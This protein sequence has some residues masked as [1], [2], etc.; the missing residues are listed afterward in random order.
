M[1][2][3]RVLTV[4][5]L[6]ALGSLLFATPA[7]AAAPLELTVSV[8]R[9]TFSTDEAVPLTFTVTN[10][11]AGACGLVG[12]AEGT[13]QVTAVT[14][15]GVALAPDY[16]EADYY[17]G[18]EDALRAG[19]T[20]AQPGGQVTFASDGVVAVA[21]L[22]AGDGLVSRWD[23]SRPGRYQV[24][25]V[26]QVPAL[27]GAQTC[28]GTTAP[29]T[30]AFTV[31]G[32]GDPAR[33]GLLVALVVILALL[34]VAGVLVLLIRRR[35]GAAAAL[36]LLLVLPA[37]VLA[38]QRADARILSELDVHD[39]VDACIG[40]FQAAGDP[41]GLLPYLQDIHTPPVRVH[42]IHDGRDSQP[43]PGKPGSVE[44]DGNSKKPAEGSDI[45]WDPQPSFELDNVPV[46]ACSAL[47]HELAHAVDINK[48]ALGEALCGDSGVKSKEV[49]ATTAENAYRATQ[50]LDQR[51]SYHGT[52][53]PADPNSCE[54]PLQQDLRKQG[55][56]AQAAPGT[57]SRTDGDPHLGTY[58]QF[59]YD[60]QLVGEFV[61][62]RST[63]GQPLEIQ[64]R[65]SPAGQ[66][67]NQSLNTAVA[68]RVG[69][70]KVGFYLVDGDIVVHRDGTAVTLPQGR[71]AL[72]DGASITRREGAVA[73]SG[74]GYTVEWP[75]GST[76]WL[77]RISGWGLR[78]LTALAPARKGTV[79]G[80]FGDFDGNPDNDLVDRSGT[81]VPPEQVAKF[82]DA[83]RVTDAESLFDYAAGQS[84]ATFTDR[85]FP[86]KPVTVADLPADQ[87]AAA[88]ELCQQ[89]GVTDPA[90]LDEC[91]LDVVVTGQTA[92]AVSAAQSSADAP[93]AAQPSGPG[94][95]GA[96]LADGGTAKGTLAG[97]ESKTFPLDLA[98]APGL[99]VAD[100]TGSCGV[101]IKVSVG[102]D[103]PFEISGCY[104]LP[105]LVREDK[106]GP[107][108]LTVT[109]T[110]QYALRIV[111]LK[112]RT[113]AAR[114]GTDVSGNLDTPGRV[115]RVQF[116]AGGATGVKVTGGAGDCDHVQ[117]RVFDATT[118]ER[119][120]LDV[121]G[122]LCDGLTQ[123]LPDPAGRYYVE[124]LA[125]GGGVSGGYTFHLDRSG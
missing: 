90:R 35:R 11:A 98:G 109:G 62:S 81:A 89:V 7:R 86:D 88:R 68:L 33:T 52:P 36:A 24:T 45:Y 103:R 111:T 47:Y 120:G 83:W 123:D 64:T 106:P 15:D 91:I 22:P 94:S 65:Q 55:T 124:V 27:S 31:T 46:D 53:L 51:K 114:L 5:A 54:G 79:V 10:R 105:V 59:H 17:D 67:R 57:C 14:R 21:P 63:S 121:P 19:L 8:P 87:V 102:T 78:A 23:T 49:R 74:D 93:P 1:K 96:G 25:V 28:A 110:G 119:L 112:P 38:G 58:D 43:G 42:A 30:V 60:L 85:T 39:A 3:V 2:V 84:T 92:F 118:G 99:W 101:T 20:T 117:L 50:G 75:D 4:A 12:F 70:H 26:Y 76:L 95:T 82:G 66:S 40:K 9:Q 6:A 122:R 41:A 13:V 18:I 37:S 56:C 34:V 97:G 80:L 61:A 116:D 69:T 73:Y 16:G 32:G 44:T 29:A 48:G 113:V 107:F 108:T 125:Y 71:T 104:G 100:T 77:D 115:D 72:G